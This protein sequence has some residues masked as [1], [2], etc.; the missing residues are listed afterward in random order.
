MKK[1]RPVLLASIV[2][3]ALAVLA[4]LSPLAPWRETSAAGFA[5]D[6][7]RI[8]SI[9]PS[10]TNVPP[11]RQIVFQFNRR[12]VPVGRMER[13]ADEVPISI[14]PPLPCEWRWINTSALACQLGEDDAFQPATRYDIA[15]RPEIESEDGLQLTQTVQHFFETERPMV[16][17]SYFRTWTGPGTP[18]V[19]LTFN[20]RLEASAVAEHVFIRGERGERFALS[21]EPPDRELDKPERY[22]VVKPVTPLP[23]DQRVRLV[24]DAGLVS[25]EG[26]ASD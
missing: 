15:V 23:L 11:A 13:T 2:L 9:T 22:W 25:L 3:A 4:A 10:G 16:T 14:H 20:Q 7:L 8:T 21:A 19:R 24:V 12:V 26:P 5:Q 1:R 18:N 6:T 17:N